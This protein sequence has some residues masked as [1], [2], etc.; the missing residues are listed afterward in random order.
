M[1]EIK[2]IVCGSVFEGRCERGNHRVVRTCT[3]TPHDDDLH[4]DEEHQAAWNG[5]TW[6]VGRCG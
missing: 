4:H 6:L 1:Y 2:R 5:S 3:R